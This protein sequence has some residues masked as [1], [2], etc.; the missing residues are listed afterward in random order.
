MPTDPPSFRIER[1]DPARHDR[2]DFDCGIA[3]LDNYL[4]L[5]AKK[6]QRDDMSRIHVIVEEGSST[7]LGYHAINTGAMNVDQLERRPQGAPRHGEI[8]VLF[9]GQVAVDRRAQGRGLGGILLH[10]VFEKAVTVAD[11]AGCHAIL[12]DVISDDGED[13]FLRRRAW[14]AS[15]GFEPFTSNPSRMFM[16]MKQ[17]RATVQ[18]R[19]QPENR[20]R[21]SQANEIAERASVWAKR[22]PAV[23]ESVLGIDVGWSETKRTNAVCRLNWNDRSVDWEIERFRAT[24]GERE[25]AI[26]RVVGDARLSAVA[27]DGPLRNGFDLIGRYRSAERL[28]SR[29]DILRIGKPGPANAPFGKELNRQANLSACILKKHHDVCDARHD[30]KIDKKAIVEAFPTTFLGVLIDRPEA[31]GESPAARSDRYFKYLVENDGLCRL[32]ECLLPGRD[33]GIKLSRVT[34]HDDRAALVCALTALC[35]AKNRFSAVGDDTDG[36]IVLPPRSAIADWAWKSLEENRD[37]DKRERPA[38]IGMSLSS[39]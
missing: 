13:A 23:C 11:I 22:E 30:S 17:V 3:R 38:I 9:L 32:F 19:R 28:L 8:P 25:K 10:H 33:L 16:V 35:I 18:A 29:G 39:M 26:G 34:N 31:A 5:S 7:I 15:Y 1:F 37:R 27:I 20:G 24:P 14:Y 36:W 21:R 12:L 2:T 4:K 6:Q